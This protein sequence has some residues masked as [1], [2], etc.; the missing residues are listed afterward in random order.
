[1]N[2]EN[3]AELRHSHEFAWYSIILRNGG[4]TDGR[5]DDH[6]DDDDVDPHVDDIN[7]V[8]LRISQLM[9]LTHRKP[10]RNELT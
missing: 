9:I 6:D 10:H 3:V 2:Q 7:Q 1:M 4:E 5:D 8:F